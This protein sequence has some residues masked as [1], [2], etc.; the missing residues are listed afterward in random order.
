MLEDQVVCWEDVTVLLVLP[1]KREDELDV[2]E[3]W[4]LVLF[5]F[6]KSYH[7]LFRLLVPMS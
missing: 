1:W 6:G 4:Q 3:E 2:L 5:S 7:K